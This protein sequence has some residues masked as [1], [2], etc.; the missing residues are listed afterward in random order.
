MSF[1]DPFGYPYYVYV[2]MWRSWLRRQSGNAEVV[3][4]SP[5]GGE[6]LAVGRIFSEQIY[7]RFLPLATH[8]TPPR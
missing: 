3:G 2:A 4:L 8:F 1:K 5:T 7:K 6:K